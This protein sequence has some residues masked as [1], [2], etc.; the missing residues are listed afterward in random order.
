MKI[1]QDPRWPTAHI[2]LKRLYE[3]RV[4]MSQTEFGIAF[5][6]GTQG[7]VWQYL[8]GYTPLNYDAAAKFAKGLRCTISDFSPEMANA[9]EAEIL[10]FLGRKLRRVAALLALVMM[11]FLLSPPPSHASFNITSNFLRIACRRV[12]AWLCR[13]LTLT[14]PFV[15]I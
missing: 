3:E 14:Y 13:V 6:L 2:E 8:N 5:G 9:F 10:P 7:M 12:R 15:Y 4:K 11:P 1:S